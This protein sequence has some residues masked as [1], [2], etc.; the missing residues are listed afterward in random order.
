M[1][2]LDEIEAQVLRRQSGERQRGLPA[3][4]VAAEAADE[5]GDVF[6]LAV[7]AQGVSFLNLCPKDWPKPER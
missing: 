3:D 1:A 7:L 4:R 5:N 2:G 6:C